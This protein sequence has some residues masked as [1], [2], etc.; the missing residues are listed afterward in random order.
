MAFTLKQTLKRAAVLDKEIMEVGAEMDVSKPQAAQA[1]AATARAQA[2]VGL[3]QHPLVV[4]LIRSR[5]LFFRFL[6][7]LS[8]ESQTLI[9][10]L[11]LQTTTLRSWQRKSLKG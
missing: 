10:L 1:V 5:S 6:E 8:S 4:V 9:P 7:H 3:P 11:P 2:R